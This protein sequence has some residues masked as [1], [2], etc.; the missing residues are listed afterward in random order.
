MLTWRHVSFHTSE[1]E[2]PDYHRSISPNTCTTRHNTTCATRAFPGKRRRAS[3]PDHMLAGTYFSEYL[4][5]LVPGLP[6]TINQ[7]KK[8]L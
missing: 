1:T 4:G 6:G 7:N 2:S 8:P 5:I 3:G